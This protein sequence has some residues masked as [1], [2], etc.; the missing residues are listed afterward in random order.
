MAKTIKNQEEKI[1]KL[2]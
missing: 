1:Y 2:E